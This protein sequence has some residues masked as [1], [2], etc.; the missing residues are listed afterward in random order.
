MLDAFFVSFGVCILAAQ[1]LLRMPKQREAC[2]MQI[3]SK[4]IPEITPRRVGICVSAL[5]CLVGPADVRSQDILA[6][7]RIDA[8]KGM[9]EISIVLRPNAQSEVLPLGELG[10]Y[11]EVT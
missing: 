2:I 1:F 7:H 10:D 11:L 3:L 4:R 9:S 5:I 8:L 6:Q